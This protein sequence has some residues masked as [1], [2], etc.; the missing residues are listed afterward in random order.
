M[1]RRRADR[2]QLL[3]DVTGGLPPPGRSESLP[4][5]FGDGEPL[6][7]CQALDFPELTVVQEDLQSFCHDKSLGDS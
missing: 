5:P 2:A 3:L 4:H 1:S 6:R 7:P